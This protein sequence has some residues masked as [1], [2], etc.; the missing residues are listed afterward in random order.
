M[1]K[2]T[3]IV[4]GTATMVLFIAATYLTL[5]LPTTTYELYVGDTEAS[6]GSELHRLVNSGGENY[7]LEFE[8]IHYFIFMD[9]EKISV[10][11]SELIDNRSFLGLKVLGKS[12]LEQGVR[13]GGKA[14][15]EVI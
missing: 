15:G 14:S 5:G 7:L 6:D 11:S 9:Q 2:L 3:L 8:G 13:L 10:P 4:L 12:E 1:K